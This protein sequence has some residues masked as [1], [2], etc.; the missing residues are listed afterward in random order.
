MAEPGSQ[1]YEQLITDI[2]RG[3]LK[4]PQ[5][6]RKFI[7]N[8]KKSAE[9]ID[10]ILKKYPI[11]TFVFWETDERLRSIRNIGNF[12]F[13]DPHEGKFIN[14]VLDGQQRIT[15]I[16]AVMKGKKV[17]NDNKEVDYSNI[18]INLEAEE[19]ETI[20]FTDGVDEE[21]FT[22]IKVVDLLEGDFKFLN[23]YDEKYHKK[24]ST[25]K[26]RFTSYNYSVIS[27]KDAAIDVATEVFTRLNVGGK[28]LSLFE[29]MV[30]KTYD[31]SK[32]FDLAEK[33]DKL[34]EELEKVKY[35]TISNATVLQVISILLKKDCRK[36]QIL[37]LDKQKVIEIWDD[38]EDAIMQT[39]DH[40]RSLYNIP[41]SRMLPY[42]A[43][44]VPFSYYFHK[45]KKKPTGDVQ[46]KLTDMF[47]RI[48]FGNRYSS[49]VESKIAQDVKRI[50]KIFSGKTPKYDWGINISPQDIIDN[51]LFST[52]RSYIKAVLAIMASK[53]P[54]RFDDNSEVIID[55]S[56]LKIASSKNYHHFFPKAYM[57]KKHVNVEDT[58]VNNIVNITIVDDFLNKRKIKDHPPSKYMKKFANE[59]D[60]IKATMKTHFIGD[61]EIFGVLSN[62][63]E[64]FMNK[65]SK[66][67]SKEIKKHIIE[68]KSDTSGKLTYYKE[69][70]DEDD[71]DET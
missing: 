8:L 31:A 12:N 6:Q 10:S 39:I 32:G 20:V 21:K 5:F 35:D 66:L 55:N 61:L 2:E 23:K 43:L 57:K 58:L 50:D 51:G 52:S 22:H 47:W 16:Y 25:Y 11:G 67:I 29:I 26:S 9:L 40:F 65:R 59:N 41:V 1:T 36:K 17:I 53:H 7:W 70:D 56:H 27:L 68:H 38:A 69:T 60:K 49:A 64:T 19:E 63:F 37:K 13:P 42:N 45:K 62:N 18:Y 34:I 44:I 28:P 48:S 33:Y 71:T 24:L 30:A 46:K 54:K 15:S 4:I 3:Q 14:Y